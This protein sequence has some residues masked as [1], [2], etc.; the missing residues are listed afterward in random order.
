MN[1]HTR[2]LVY[3]LGTIMAGFVSILKKG[4]CQFFK[5]HPLIILGCRV[6]GIHNISKRG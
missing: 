6:T 2:F 5:E 1:E 3:K 4:F